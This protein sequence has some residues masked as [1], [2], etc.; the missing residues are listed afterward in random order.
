MNPFATFATVGPNRIVDK[1]M[2]EQKR[3]RQNTASKMNAVDI[4]IGLLLE[5]SKNLIN[6]NPD[7]IAIYSMVKTQLEYQGII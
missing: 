2:V 3:A 7:P 4:D 1:L 5:V 6:G